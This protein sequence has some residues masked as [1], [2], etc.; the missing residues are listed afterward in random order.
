[1]QDRIKNQEDGVS[2]GIAPDIP[3]ELRQNLEY[4]DFV[5]VVSECVDP[6]PSMRPL[7]LKVGADIKLFRWRC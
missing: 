2:S 6:Q 3:I 5:S 4:A 7:D 1:L